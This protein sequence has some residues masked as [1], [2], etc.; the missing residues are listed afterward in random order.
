MKRLIVL[1]AMLATLGVTLGNALAT[2]DPPRVP[3]KG[4]EGPD[5]Q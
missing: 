5:V 3:P 4:I 2:V 1:V